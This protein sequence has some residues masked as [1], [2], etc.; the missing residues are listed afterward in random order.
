MSLTGRPADTRQPDPSPTAVPRTLVLVRHGESTWLPERRFQGRRDP[1]LSALGR[2]QAEAAGRRL[3][4]PGRAPALPIPASAPLAIW[5]SPLRRAAQTAASIADARGGDAPLRAL[6]DLL[7]LGQGDWEGLTHDEVRTRYGPQLA[8]WQRDPLSNHAPGGESLLGALE[9]AR[10][11]ARTILGRGAG[12]GRG[13]DGDPDAGVAPDT[14]PGTA[15]PPPTVDAVDPV[16]GYEDRLVGSRPAAPPDWAIIVAHDGV[17]RLLMLD[18]LGVD[19]ARYWSF[20]FA[21]ASVTIL[22]VTGAGARLRAHNLEAQLAAV[23]RPDA[24]RHVGVDR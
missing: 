24:D 5:H 19:I 15:S 6:D 2:R 8:A 3:A 4:W 14:R 16:L 18:L 12:D 22:E 9:R 23:D 20:P 11:A 7:E 1:P 10:S 13:K 21:L 17:L